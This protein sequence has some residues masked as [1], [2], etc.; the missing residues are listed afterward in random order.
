[1]EKNN[2]LYILA[3]VA[4][5]H[6]GSLGI[7]HSY[8]DAVAT[9][10]ADGIK[11]QTHIAQAESS[12]HEPFRVNFSY[13]DASRFDYWKRMEFSRDQWAQ[14]KAHCD[15]VG[16]D[17]ISSPFSNSAVDLLEEIG[18][19]QYKVGSGEVTNL[20]LIEKIARTGKKIILSSG[21]S[22]YDELDIAVNLI[23]SRGNGLS[24]MQCTSKY[25]V[26]PELLGLNVLKDLSD[27]Y[28]VPVGLSDHSGEIFSSLAG[29]SLGASLI[30]AHVV[31]DKRMFGPDASSSLTIDQFSQMVEGIRFIETALT[32]PIDK[33]DT[34]AFSNEKKFL[35]NPLQSI[36]HCPRDRF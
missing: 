19:S 15:G 6:D 7:L 30:E 13:E 34:N 33:N 18:V 27:R 2:R 1:M 3:E 32:H 25:P 24:L 14:V 16:L 17:F 31:F 22:S 20:L 23:K 8:I 26:P 21:M 5:A 9:S 10:G 12:I 35:K 4:Q 28:R 36:N 11:F 29:V